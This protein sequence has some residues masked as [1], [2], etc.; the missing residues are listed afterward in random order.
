MYCETCAWYDL[1]TG[2]CRNK[3]PVVRQD[4]SGKYE[5]EFI[6]MWPE[7]RTDDWCGKWQGV[8]DNGNPIV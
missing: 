4:V 8:D 1:N 7:T 5:D 6:T 3:P 2:Y